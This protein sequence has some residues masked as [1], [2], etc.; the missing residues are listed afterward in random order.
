VFAPTWRRGFGVAFQ[1]ARLFPHLDV[2]ANILFAVDGAPGDWDELI[3]ALDL[4]A[5]MHRRVAGL[6]GGERQRVSLARALARPARL[7]LLDE[8]TAMVD[9]ARRRRIDTYL[10]A[11]AD[12]TATLL[13]SHETERLRPLADQVLL[14]AHGR[15]SGPFKQS[16]GVIDLA[17]RGGQ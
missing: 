12:R 6:S 11:V 7:L 8:P 15:L 10:R 13:V 9:D 5:L 14:V 4:G 16:D 17:A 2:K 3:S 1:D